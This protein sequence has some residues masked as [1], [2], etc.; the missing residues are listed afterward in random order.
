MWSV[1]YVVQYSKFNFGWGSAQAPVWRF[2]DSL[3]EKGKEEKK[4]QRGRGQ[5]YKKSESNAA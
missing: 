2:T 3:G 5:K 1:F 4:G